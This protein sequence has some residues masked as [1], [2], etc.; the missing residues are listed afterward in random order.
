MKITCKI[1]ALFTKN[2]PSPTLGRAV[3]RCSHFNHF[4]AL[5]FVLGNRTEEIS[6]ADA[7]KERRNSNMERKCQKSTQTV[8]SQ[9]QCFPT[10]APGTTTIAS[11]KKQI[12][13]LLKFF[14][15]KV[16][17]TFKFS[18]TSNDKIVCVVTLQPDLEMV[19]R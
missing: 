19:E 17:K 2:Y 3:F 16:V 12:L 18:N 5:V 13:Q 1:V 9:V 10:T 4:G 7:D 14:E 11:R 15:S 8:I 6:K